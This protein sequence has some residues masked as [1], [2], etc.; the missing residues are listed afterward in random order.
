MKLSIFSFFLL[1][2]AGLGAQEQ[3]AILVRGNIWSRGL[4]GI[5]SN[6]FPVL[7]GEYSLKTGEKRADMAFSVWICG[8]PLAFSRNGWQTRQGIQGY[9]AFQHREEETFFI[10]VPLQNNQ[11]AYTAMFRFTGDET[12]ALLNR[13]IRAWS[14]RFLYFLSSIKNASDISLPAV[15]NF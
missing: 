12:E 8:E 3:G 1:T 7:H 5:E 9:T 2:A 6:D 10:A 13:L 11:G 4:P 15:I 14:S